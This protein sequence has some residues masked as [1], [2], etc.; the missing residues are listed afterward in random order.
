MSLRERL[1]RACKKETGF[2]CFALP[3]CIGLESE[4]GSTGEEV[5]VDRDSIRKEIMDERDSLGDELYGTE[6]SSRHSDRNPVVNESVVHD[7][8][9]THEGGAT[10]GGMLSSSTPLDFNE[11]MRM[12]NNDA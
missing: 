12:V 1:P 9:A 2:P 7:G 4:S 10:G 3:D 5:V 8:G 6:G 11:L